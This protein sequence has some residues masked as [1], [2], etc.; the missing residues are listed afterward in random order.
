MLYVGGSNHDNREVS[1]APEVSS[2]PRIPDGR[3]AVS[4]VVEHGRLVVRG[5]DRPQDAVTLHPL[6]IRERSSEAGVV[7]PSNHQRL[8]EPLDVDADLTVVEAT[9]CAGGGIDVLLS[10]DHRMTLSAEH[11]DAAFG[12][13]PFDE[14]PSAQAWIADD[15]DVPSFDYATLL[16]ESSADGSMVTMLER[17]FRHGFFML[18]GTPA[19]P[20]ALHEITA[21]FGRISSTNFGTLFDVRT[22]AT[23]TDL[24]YT[25]VALTAH[26]DQPYR[27]PTP[28]L[29]FLHTITND[30]PG[31]SSTIVDGLAAVLDLASVDPEA[32][33]VLATLPIEFR[34]DIG[35]DVKVGRSPLIDLHVD[36]TL[37]QLRFSPRLDFAPA[38]DPATL[39]VYYRGRRWLARELNSPRRQHE[40]RMVAGDVLIVDNHRVLHGRT[41][42]DPTRG[43][44]HLQGCYIDHDG[45][46]TA[47]RLAVR[48]LER[49]GQSPS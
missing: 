6:W 46:E 22:E 31:G 4:A 19:K 24:A 10:D 7:D 26:L 49:G 9:P 27:S 35:T 48:R 21:H 12:T 20:G 16:D 13:A 18:R 8:V 25:P 45:P 3:R 23:P 11:V 14:P 17:F 44:R 33:A 32:Y 28:G 47:W 38:T 39:D 2:E 42:F 43:D 36:G 15:I 29:Q 5:I 34:Y 40:V 1:R 37:R 41:A 30:A